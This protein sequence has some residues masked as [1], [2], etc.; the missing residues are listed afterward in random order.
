MKGAQRVLAKKTNQVEVDNNAEYAMMLLRHT[1]QIKEQS[2]SVISYGQV[3]T[4]LTWFNT[5]VA[6]L[7]IF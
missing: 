4:F 2:K 3:L 5:K 7:I 6:L 1:F